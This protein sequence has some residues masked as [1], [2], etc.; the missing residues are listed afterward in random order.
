MFNHNFLISSARHSI[1]AAFGYIQALTVITCIAMLPLGGKAQ[2]QD[3]LAKKVAEYEAD[4]FTERRPFSID[5]KQYGNYNSSSTLRG[6]DLPDGEFTKWSQLSASANINLLQNRRWLVQANGFYRYVSAEYNFPTSTTATSQ[7]V[8]RDLHYHTEG[9]N[10]VY[11]SKLFGKTVIYSGSVN[12]DWSER[13]LERVRGLF[14]GAIVLKANNRTKIN[15]GILY[16]TDPGTFIRVIP[17]FLLEHKFNERLMADVFL[18]RYAYLRKKVF[19]N[20][21]LS[22][23]WELDPQTTFFLNDL[24]ENGTTYQYRQVDV[25]T[26]LL[27]EHILPGSITLSLRAG[28][29][30]NPYARTFEKDRSFTDYTWEGRADAAPYAN[31]G[32]SFNPFSKRKK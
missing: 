12:V 3:S 20:G 19:S 18:P 28:V 9:L 31:I 13:S 29:R 7:T 6:Q 32:F 4:K 24:D 15:V 8:S 2:S 23:G 5:Y 25:N 1:G 10:V 21:R 30:I 16:T 26:G 27:Y 22:A 11:F 14:T 17:T